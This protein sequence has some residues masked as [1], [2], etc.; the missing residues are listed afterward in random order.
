MNDDES[1]ASNEKLK[2]W[3]KFGIK[4]DYFET[5][6]TVYE[7]PKNNN[8]HLKEYVEYL[9]QLDE[10]HESSE[11]NICIPLNPPIV[12]KL[13]FD[14]SSNNFIQAFDEVK[15]F[16]LYAAEAC[17]KFRVNEETSR[18]SRLR[19]YS[20]LA[21]A[22][23]DYKKLL[24]ATP[25]LGNSKN[26]MKALEIA[27]IRKNDKSKKSKKG[28]L[29]KEV[30]AGRRIN[31]ILEALYG[32]WHIIDLHDNITKEFLVN[33]NQQFIDNLVN[34]IEF[35]SDIIRSLPYKLINN[36]GSNHQ[37]SLAHT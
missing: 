18:R 21:D 6:G 34:G 32:Q 4:V 27:E 16:I 15:N 8:E 20:A 31:K 23:D 19:W 37:Y 3:A 33:N 14:D 12:P 13:N 9:A 10:T 7:D 26:A 2:K 11:S 29:A 1:D 24:D 35:P 17:Q 30:M 5:A 36:S 22:Y 28:A 25:N